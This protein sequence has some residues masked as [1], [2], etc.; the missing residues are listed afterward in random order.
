MIIRK[1]QITPRRLVRRAEDVK[2]TQEKRR[3]YW[4]EAQMAYCFTKRENSKL[5]TQ[6]CFLPI[7]LGSYTYSREWSERATLEDSFK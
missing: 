3:K 2:N 1:V 6:F 4:N 7:E 5:F